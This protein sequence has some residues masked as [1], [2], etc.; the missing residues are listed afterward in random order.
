MG[1]DIV[2]QY[3]WDLGFGLFNDNVRF[4]VPHIKSDIP[5]PTDE[6]EQV[7]LA[8]FRSSVVKRIHPR[9]ALSHPGH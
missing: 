2:N 8:K 3:H 7:Q 4:Q 6:L 5:C 9:V 1:N